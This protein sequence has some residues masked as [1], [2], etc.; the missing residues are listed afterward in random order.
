MLS[1][2]QR[3][4]HPSPGLG[5]LELRRTVMRWP[6]RP[7]KQRDSA[8]FIR[9][10]K[11]LR[12]FCRTGQDARAEIWLQRGA[13]S[14]HRLLRHFRRERKNQTP[15]SSGV[16]IDDI[17]CPVCA[18]QN[19][20]CQGIFEAILDCTLQRASTVNGVETGFCNVIQQVIADP[21]SQL[22]ARQSL[23]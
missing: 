9:K 11:L 6:S 21:Q 19:M 8:T 15:V 23:V 7:P 4:V 22:A 10:V 13:E 14:G 12:R 3:P 18:P 5:E 20:L 17:T 2:T 16:H 1:D